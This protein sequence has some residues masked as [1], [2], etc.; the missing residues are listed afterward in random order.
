MSSPGEQERAECKVL[1]ACLGNPDR[2]DD[3][4]GPKVA[5]ALK[6][7]LPAGA[8]LVVRKGDMLALIEDWAGC[9]AVVCV[10]AAA[11]MGTP[12]RIHRVDLARET[13]PAETAPTSGHAFGL[14]EAVQ[15]AC[16]LERAPAT[17]IVYAVE[18]ACFD[19]GAPMTV[20]VAAAADEVARR[21]IDEARRLTQ[22][23]H[24]RLSPATPPVMSG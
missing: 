1:V 9:D 2:G 12:G 17:I 10:D 20:A 15:L 19:A 5:Q 14:A 22:G 13:L 23:Q 7:R 11:T 3:G 4:I 8:A 16:T 18:G 6:G 21:V 24:L